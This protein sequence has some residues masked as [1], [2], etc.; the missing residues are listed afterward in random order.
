MSTVHETGHAKNV[1][2]FETLISFVTGYGATYN[3][4]NTAI[5]LVNLQSKAVDA[6]TAIDNV[7]TLL[8]GYSNA[9]TTRQ[10]AFEPMGQL[11]TRLLNALKATS[12]SQP[13]IESA[14]TNHR[15]LQ[16]RRASAKLTEEEKQ[17]LT[18]TGKEVNQISSSQLSFDSQLD[19]FDKQIKL[20]T[21][22]PAYAPNEVELQVSSLTALYNDL[23]QK[24]RG[25]INEASALSSGRINRDEVFY[26]AET[27]MNTVALDAKNYAKSLFGVGAAQYKQISGLTFKKVKI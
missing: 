3:P 22:I 13:I 14:A 27:G 21:S 12:A 10:I 19:T 2:N 1:A 25:A 16:G 23:L 5:Q 26:N 6:K 17:T 4:S 20:L 11:S 9:I 24:N 8:A 18:A 7:N 15:K